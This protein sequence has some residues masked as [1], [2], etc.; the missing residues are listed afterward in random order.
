MAMISPLEALKETL[1]RTSGPS[2]KRLPRFS[3]AIAG[4][5]GIGGRICPLAMFANKLDEGL[6]GILGRNM[7]LNAFPADIEVYLPG[8][9][10]DVTEVGVS[11]LP[12]TINDAAHDGDGDAFQV[13]GSF[14]DALGRGLKVK[15][16]RPQ[17]GQATY[18]VFVVRARAP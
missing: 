12:R 15:S 4:P 2:P 17:L 6:H 11:H 9:A 13:S 1:S 16:V 3:T 5:S 10:S 8:G 7:V 18:S 14:A